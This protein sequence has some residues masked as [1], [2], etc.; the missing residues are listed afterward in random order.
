MDIVADRQKAIEQGAKPRRDIL[1]MFF[2]TVDPITGDK[3][4][5][6]EIASES[7][8]QLYVSHHPQCAGLGPQPG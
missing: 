7:L 2:D 8:V 5:K 1:Q 4:T 3:L 6:E